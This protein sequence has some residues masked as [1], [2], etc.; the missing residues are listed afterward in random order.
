MM[1]DKRA[2]KE[3]EFPLKDCQCLEDKWSRFG[4][5][6]LRYMA[7][8]LS[9]G[10][11][12]LDFY[13]WLVEIDKRNDEMRRKEQPPQPKRRV[14]IID[15]SKIKEEEEYTASQVKRKRLFRK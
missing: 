8:C 3:I 7:R 15:T 5:C 14:E 13:E 10:I 12:P 4:R 2:Y 9:K 6:Y 1:V 11:K